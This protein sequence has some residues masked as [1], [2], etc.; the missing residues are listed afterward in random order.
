MVYIKFFSFLIF[1]LGKPVTLSPSSEEIA[2][3]FA[4]LIG[5]DWANNSTFQ[6]NF[7]TDFLNVLEQEDPL[8]CFLFFVL[9]K[10]NFYLVPN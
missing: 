2:T 1:N 10:I 5:T 8:V 6:Q 3:F 7:F 9:N 4:A